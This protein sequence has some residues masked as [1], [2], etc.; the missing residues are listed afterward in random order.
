MSNKENIEMK[1]IWV[2][3]HKHPKNNKLNANF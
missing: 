3:I 1:F 2:Y